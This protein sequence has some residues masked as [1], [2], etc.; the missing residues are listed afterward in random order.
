LRIIRPFVTAETILEG[1]SIAKVLNTHGILSMPTSERDMFFVLSSQRAPGQIST[2]FHPVWL[3]PRI[4]ITVRVSPSDI[5]SLVGSSAA[6]VIYPPGQGFSPPILVSDQHEIPLANGSEPLRIILLQN[7]PNSENQLVGIATPSTIFQPHPPES[8]AS[9]T[10]TAVDA[11]AFTT[12][13][14]AANKHDKT[15][16]IATGTVSKS[17]NVLFAHTLAVPNIITFQIQRLLRFKLL[18]TSYRL[19]LYIAS[20]VVPFLGTHLPL[21]IVPP[22]E[23]ET[24]RAEADA[25]QE[26]ARKKEV[27]TTL[28]TPEEP[29][30]DYSLY[31]D[32]EPVSGEVHVTFMGDAADEVSF[33]VDGNKIDP[34]SI[35][36]TWHGDDLHQFLLKMD[37]PSRLGISIEPGTSE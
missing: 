11:T 20:L 31:Y 25:E 8:L 10:L 7:V 16:N 13:K 27:S 3:S 30:G 9:L 1:S 6:T 36:Q 4:P 14:A 2:L 28:E 19:T 15:K 24:P 23:P 18:Y 21:K 12:T 29:T 37:A 34:W 17:S 35:V 33:T 26:E 5:K 32:V 22:Q